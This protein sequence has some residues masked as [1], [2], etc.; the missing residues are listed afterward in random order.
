MMPSTLQELGRLARAN[1]LD[2]AALDASLGQLARLGADP[3]IDA[4]HIPDDAG[5]YRA[6]ACAPPVCAVMTRQAAAG[7]RPGTEF[8]RPLAVRSRDGDFPGIGA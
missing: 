2:E 8:C 7:G 5:D 3:D 4:L 6:G 1:A